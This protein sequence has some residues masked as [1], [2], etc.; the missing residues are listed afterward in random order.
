MD[1]LLADFVAETREMLEAIGGELVAWES[2]PSDRSRLDSIFRFVHTVKG[3]CGFFD[4][5]RLEKLSHAAEGALAEARA[6]HRKPDSRFVSA[7]LAVIDRITHMTNAIEAGNPMPK[8]GDEFLIA[9]L[10]PDAADSDDRPVMAASETGGKPA[11]HGAAAPRSI[12]LPVELLDRV[13]SGVSDMVLARNDLARRLRDAGNEPTLDGPFERL[14]GI[15][16][17]VRD[18]ITRMRM[19]RIEHLY[20]A[21]PRLVRDLSA[22]L[23]K[24]VMVDFD[25]GSVELDREMI[26]MIRDPVTHL[27]RNA[28]DHGIEK[29]SDRI[30]KG[31]REIGM[32]AIAARQSGNRITI[33]ISDDGGGLNADKIGRKA[34]SSEL[35]TQAD[36]D[37]MPA[38]AV[39]NLIFE[40]GLSTADEVSAISGRGVGMDVVRANIEKIGGTI[41]VASHPGEGTIF[42][43]QIPLTLSIISALTVSVGGQRF[44]I[45][46]SYV[47]EIAHG[48]S[49]SVHFSQVGDTDLVTFRD[50]RIPCLTLNN[51]LGVNPR[52]AGP[53]Q[54]LVLLMLGSGDLFAL[55]VDKIHDQE[56]LVIKPLAPEVMHTGTY[57]GTTLLDDGSP[58]LMLD[59]PTIASRN[60]LVND[61]R[62]RPSQAAPAQ[63]AVT[64][65]SSRT[66]M[67]FTG[68]DGRVRAMGMEL[69]ARIDQVP[70]EAFDFDGERANVVID[71]QIMTLVGASSDNIQDSKVKI[72]RL[73]DSDCELA[74]AV[75][76]LGE[77]LIVTG[78]LTPCDTDAEVEGIALID[79]QP[80]PVI[81]GYRLFGL[82]GR[83]S[84]PQEVLVCRLPEDDAWAQ[85]MLAPLVTSAGYRI[86]SGDEEADV[87][88]AIADRDA[89]PSE[90]ARGATIMLHTD[91]TGSEP[92]AGSVYRYDRAALIGALNT[93]RTTK[94]RKRA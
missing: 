30:A 75:A 38:E 78:E 91:L 20:N 37:A 57:A 34:V 47:E 31:K 11:E 76:E 48:A 46:Q 41:S 74:Y 81:D 36:L 50:R 2:D 19:Q 80:V 92:A 42:Y 73:S 33:T 85:R 12:R 7:V 94:S 24:Q 28:I 70:A 67:S 54:R 88:I 86:S 83:A 84:V 87:T 3:N 21:L 77:S 72:L 59:I 39:T 82:H 27:I 71:G 56:D 13:M 51:V 52:S 58:V 4:F 10:A 93:V 43:L 22:E 15:L 17:D 66:L 5:P 32:L 68:F 65:E 60:G 26:E 45:P 63:D 53:D 44:A 69:V 18:A 35:I 6:G 14:S 55:A 8:Q 9:A 40:A 62:M 79:G 29:P 1:D 64:Q 25:G 89:E 61:V 16:T 49:S 90:T 23:G